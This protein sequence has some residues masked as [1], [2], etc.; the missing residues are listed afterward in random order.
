MDQSEAINPSSWAGVNISGQ[1]AWWGVACTRLGSPQREKKREPRK[2]KCLLPSAELGRWGGA[3]AGTGAGFQVLSPGASRTALWFP[4]RGEGF[5]RVSLGVKDPQCFNRRQPKPV[6]QLG[7]KWGEGEQ[8][9]SGKP[10]HTPPL[11]PPL[12]GAS[13]RT[14]RMS[15]VTQ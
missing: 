6:A 14:G 9:L 7:S 8:Q 13:L 5:R 10:S 4:R 2:W 12:P 15:S 1:S 11:T 3:G